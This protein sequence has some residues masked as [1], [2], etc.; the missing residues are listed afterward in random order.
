MWVVLQDLAHD[1]EWR[2]GRLVASGK[3]RGSLRNIF[4]SILGLRPLRCER[5][6][7]GGSRSCPRRRAR[8]AASDSRRTRCGCRQDSRSFRPLSTRRARPTPRT[9][10]PATVDP[11]TTEPCTGSAHTATPSEAGTTSPGTPAR[12]RRRRGGDRPGNGRRARWISG[13][14]TREGPG[15]PARRAGKCLWRSSLVDAGVGRV[16]GDGVDRRRVRVVVGG[17]GDRRVLRRGRGGAGGVVGCAGRGSSVSR[18]WSKPTQ[19]RAL[20]DGHDPVTD[21]AVAGGVAGAD[22]EGV[23][24]RRSRRRSRCRCCGRWAPSRWPTR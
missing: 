18:G 17:V 9:Q 24:S 12:P 23:R 14:A 6:A 5:S 22:G 21:A 15:W 8:R 10:M 1:A 11:G 16:D 13:W 19:L 2:E 4:V 3:R 20:I 7:T